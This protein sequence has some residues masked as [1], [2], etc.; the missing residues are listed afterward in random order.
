MKKT[1]LKRGDITE[2][3]LSRQRLS[4][5]TLQA[6]TQAGVARR[7]PRRR[8][9]AEKQY[10]RYCALGQGCKDPKP[11]R[12]V[13]CCSQHAKCSHHEQ[14]KPHEQNACTM[15]SARPASTCSAISKVRSTSWLVSI[16]SCGC[17]HNHREGLRFL[18]LVFNCSFVSYCSDSPLCIIV[19]ATYS[20]IKPLSKSTS[21]ISRLRNAPYLLASCYTFCLNLRQSSQG[22]C[23]VQVVILS[24]S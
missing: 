21:L 12:P 5:T 3:P 20:D 14:E 7:I 9:S 22:L 18:T 16:D 8:N 11:L 24:L 1:G 4:V 23:R 13:R 2:L 6:V 15:Q 19:T 17:A 10:V